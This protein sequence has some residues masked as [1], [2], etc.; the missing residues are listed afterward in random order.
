M[1]R[2]FTIVELLVV[3]AIIG[4][5]VALLLPAI[6]A[7]REAARRAQCSNNMKQLG[8]AA[9][10]RHDSVGTYPASWVQGDNSITWARSLLPYLEYR[11]LYD[12]WDESLGFLEGPNGELA[13]TYV[14]VYKCASAPS[15]N[16]YEY[17]AENS[18]GLFGTLDYKGCQGANASD[19]SVSH[20]NL[21][22]WLPGVVN[23]KE[24]AAK[25]ITDGLSQTIL[26]VESVGG[27]RLYGPGGGPWGIA[28]IWYATDGGW[29]GRAFSSVSAV[30]YAQRW[31][32]A[33]C[34]VNCSNMYDYGPYSFHPGG[35]QAVLCDGSVQ[36]LNEQINP[37]I[38]AGYYPYN[39]GQLISSQ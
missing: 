2:G 18:P 10:A 21:T 25:K 13:A 8:L 6:Q 17:V 16:V 24:L 29:V 14:P 22:G 7:A 20:W 30:N 23:R 32:L 38:L 12:A 27:R 15:P 34:T 36:F 28:E 3:I 37:A 33:S 4:V 1:K 19:P 39:E 5:L 35:A 9:M 11:S 31:N 26:L